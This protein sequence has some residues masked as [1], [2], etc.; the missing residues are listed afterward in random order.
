MSVKEQLQ[1]YVQSDDNIL[2]AYLFGSYADGTQQRQSDVDVAIFFRHHTFDD[3]LSII[4]TLQ[5]IVHKKI[6]LVTLNEVKNLFLL[7]S[8]LNDGILLKDHPERPW[9][10]VRKEHEIKDF[11]H[12]LKYIDAA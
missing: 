2:F 8:I 12:F 5:K 6:D 7:E 1:N 4:H 10:E 3:K 9:F 11:K